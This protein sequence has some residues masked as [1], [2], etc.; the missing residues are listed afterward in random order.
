MRIRHTYGRMFLLLELPDSRAV[1]D[2]QTCSRSESAEPAAADLGSNAHLSF[3][4][5]A[6]HRVK[7]HEFQID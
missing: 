1:R 6:R 3:P 2:R 7:V 5:F 4:Q